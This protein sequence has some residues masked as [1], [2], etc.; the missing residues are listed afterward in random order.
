M[1]GVMCIHVDDIL[2]AG[3]RSFHTSVVAPF[4]SKVLIDSSSESCFFKYS[5][6]NIVQAVNGIGLHQKEYVDAISETSLSRERASRRMD[7]LQKE[8]MAEYRPL[9]G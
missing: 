8:E 1:A 4:K 6:V 7:N 2:H 3:T 5:V 9:I